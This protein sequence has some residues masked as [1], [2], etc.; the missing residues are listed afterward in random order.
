MT[1]VSLRLI[2]CPFPVVAK[3]AP[4]TTSLL[5]APGS[6]RNSNEI[7]RGPLSCATQ[8]MQR[9]RGRREIEPMKIVMAVIKPFKLDQ[10]RDALNK[11]GVQGITVAEVKAGCGTKKARKKSRA[12]VISVEG[13]LNSPCRPC[14]R[15]A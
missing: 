14:H 4:R 9:M 7:Q 15:Q 11:I 1:D 2:V 5:F 13:G 8:S 10:V 3:P 12:F 6:E